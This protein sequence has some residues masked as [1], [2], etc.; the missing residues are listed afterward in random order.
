M[1]NPIK[2]YMN[3]QFETQVSKEHY[4]KKYEH[5]ERF[6]SYYHQ[7]KL[8]ADLNPKTILE[9]GI[10]GGALRGLIANKGYEISTADFDDS[11]EPD[12]VCDIRNIPKPDDSYDLVCAF[13]VLEHIPY[14]ESLKALKEMKRVSRKNIV[15][16][17]PRSCV[18]F[19]LSF[20][21]GLPIFRRLLS[22]GFRIPFF[23]IAA[24]AG[25]KQ[26]YWELGRRGYSIS[27]FIKDL[28]GMDFRILQKGHISLNTQH[29]FVVLEK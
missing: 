23:W 10:G 17:V 25:N 15:I 9:I 18:Y 2:I 4:S 12:I 13:E 11:L 22:L 6:V 5:L 16:S 1:Q 14:E 27:R 8:I 29:Y 24:E 3:Q 26:H 20:S 28:K 19:G 21:F 7:V